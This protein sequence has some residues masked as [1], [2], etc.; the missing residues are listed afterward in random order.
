MLVALVWRD[1]NLAVKKRS[2]TLGL[3]TVAAIVLAAGASRRLGQPKQIVG[4]AGEALLER[5][6]RLAREAGAAP[7]FAVLGANFA[8]IC[9]AV[10]FD[11]AIPVFNERWEQ[12]ISSSIQAGL[13]EL[14]VRAPESAAALLL[15]CDQPRLTTEHLRALIDAF[16]GQNAPS[17]AA[18]AYADTLGIPAIFP[19]M[20]FPA[21]QALAGDKGARNLL[22]QPPCPVVSVPFAG[23]EVDID[24]PGDLDHLR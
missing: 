18:S 4:F 24:T 12:G 3:M 10:S 9:A 14:D 13:R 8:R 22:R 20:T 19:R 15:A 7:V 11:A 5:S 1:G 2:R 23:G 21:L 6:L 16:N 17:I